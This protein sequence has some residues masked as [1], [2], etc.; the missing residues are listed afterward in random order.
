[1]PSQGDSPATLQQVQF[2]QPRRLWNDASLSGKTTALVGASVLGGALVG[3]LEAGT[4]Y[5]GWA[6]GI[7]VPMVIGAMVLLAKSWICH[8]IEKIIVWWR[9][10]HHERSPGALDDLPISRHDEAGELARAFYQL[11]VHSIRRDYEARQLRRTLDHRIAEATRHATLQLRRLAMRDPL[12]DLGNRRFLEH[13]LEPLV[14]SVQE[15]HSTLACVS[16]DADYFKEVNDTL[17][18]AAGDDLLVFLGSLIR[19]NIRQED[20]A[21]RLGGDE[22][23]ILMPDCERQRVRT[24]TERLRTLFKQYAAGSALAGLPV[25]LSMGVAYLPSPGI[26]TGEELLQKADENLY[27]AK[28]A[29]KGRVVGVLN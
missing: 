1:M 12:T 2:R 25:D 10:I 5:H 29:G 26:N 4:G 24:I 22:F 14:K 20:Y 13:T 3:M 6:L 9:R 19:G 27:A 11:T 18:H 23:L 28:R 15:S 21:I 7:G 16:M 17:G 8:P